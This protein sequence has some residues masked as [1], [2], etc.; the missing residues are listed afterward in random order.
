MRLVSCIAEVVVESAGSGVGPFE[1]ATDPCG[2]RLLVGE[3]A[4]LRELVLQPHSVIE[5]E[6]DGIQIRPAADGDGAVAWNAELHVNALEECFGEFETAGAEA[7]G[8][9]G[10]GV[11]IEN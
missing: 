7:S 8:V 9:R 2:A 10:Q 11:G 5:R 4:D 3:A 1:N 6:V